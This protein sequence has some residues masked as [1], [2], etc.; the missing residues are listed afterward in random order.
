MEVIC[1]DVWMCEL[2][3]RWIEWMVNANEN[4]E[5]ERNEDEDDGMRRDERQ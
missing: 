4:E 1:M 5:Y 2:C 3:I